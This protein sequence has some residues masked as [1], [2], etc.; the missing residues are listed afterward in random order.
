VAQHSDVFHC[1]E[2]LAIGPRG[3]IYYIDADDNTVRVVDGQDTSG[4]LPA[5]V[6]AG[7]RIWIAA[8]ATCGQLDCGCVM[9]PPTARVAWP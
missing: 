6:L 2:W 7:S 4:W 8:A 9:P 1:P 5:A 3:G